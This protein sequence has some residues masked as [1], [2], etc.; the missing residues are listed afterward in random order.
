MAL[1]RRLTSARFPYLPLQVDVDRRTHAVE[2]LLDT[3]FDGD[4][5]LPPELIAADHPPDRYLPCQLADGSDVLPPIYRGVVRVG[6]MA[7]FP[8]VVVAL[9]DEPLVGPG[10][11]DRFTIILDHGQQLIVEP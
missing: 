4:V 3:G 8:I 11:A 10:V 7:T 6:D 1:S 2:A 5:A 9:G